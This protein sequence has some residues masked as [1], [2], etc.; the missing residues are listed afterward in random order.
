MFY[1]NYTIR[2]LRGRVVKTSIYGEFEEQ[3]VAKFF[4]DVRQKHS[5]RWNCDYEVV[6]SEKVRTSKAVK[7]RSAQFLQWIESKNINL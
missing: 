4:C 3:K 6:E 2:N 5:K 1:V 7:E